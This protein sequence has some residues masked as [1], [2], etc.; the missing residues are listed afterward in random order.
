MVI[1]R[2]YIGLLHG[3]TAVYMGLYRSTA[4]SS[5]QSIHGSTWDYSSLATSGYTAG[6]RSIASSYML[7]LDRHVRECESSMCG[8][9]GY[10]HLLCSHSHLIKRPLHGSTWAYIWVYMSLGLHTWV[11]SIIHGSDVKCIQFR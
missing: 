4:A 10:H 1:T 2:I 3:S 8:T 5:I 6:L 9:A 11:Y 7:G